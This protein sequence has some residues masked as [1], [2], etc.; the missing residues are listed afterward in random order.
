MPPE[1]PDT[2]DLHRPPLPAPSVS[3]MPTD[4]ARPQ[5]QQ[6]NHT[7]GIR[8]VRCNEMSS[9]RGVDRLPS[10]IREMLLRDIECAQQSESLAPKQAIDLLRYYPMV[11]PTQR[12]PER[13]RQPAT[14]ACER[15]GATFKRRQAGTWRRFC[16]ARCRAAAHRAATH[17]PRVPRAPK[18]QR[19][20]TSPVTDIGSCAHCGEAFEQH[21]RGR[22]RRYCS[23]RCRVA[24]HRSPT[25]ADVSISTA[26]SRGRSRRR[27][28][29]SPLG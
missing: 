24:A 21:A 15:C 25:T 12:L 4:A 23:A 2:H 13:L 27:R 10:P 3:Q 17:S 14:G 18:P 29:R 8:G 11:Q 16:S 19:E 20:P 6:R 22:P 26:G 1:R 9:G 7:A 28:S 5:Q